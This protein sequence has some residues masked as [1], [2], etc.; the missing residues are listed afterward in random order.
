MSRITDVPS[1]QHVL[2][3]DLE[4]GYNLFLRRLGEEHKPSNSAVALTERIMVFLQKRNV[5]AT[6]F[7]L[8]EVADKYPDLIRSIARAGHELGVHG[9]N[10]QKIFELSEQDFRKQISRTRNLLQDISGKE[11][12]G[13]RAPAFSIRPDTS[14][15]LDVLAEEGFY[16]DSSIFP[17]KGHRYGWPGFP[18]KPVR[19]TLRGGKSIIEVPMSTVRFIGRDWP[20]AGGGY[21]RIFPWWYTHIAASQ[22]IHLNQPIII[23]F[24]PYDIDTDNSS[25]PTNFRTHQLSLPWKLKWH[26]RIQNIGRSNVLKKISKLLDLGSFGTFTDLI[27]TLSKNGQTLESA[28]ILTCH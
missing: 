2:S 13:F 28:K 12:R 5:K 16:Y 9:F 17:F 8:G 15:A 19:L 21:L 1:F 20:V 18:K 27:D 10:H 3:I 4:D 25:L 26:L 14:W 24:H 6:F 11:V 23:Y 7:V 22:L